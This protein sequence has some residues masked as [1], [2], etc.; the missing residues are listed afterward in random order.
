[1][2]GEGVSRIRAEDELAGQSR[3]ETWFKVLYSAIEDIKRWGG[4]AKDFYG[5]DIKKE[6]TIGGGKSGE[7]GI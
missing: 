7:D 3:A 5:E 1:M 2:A 6:V 4:V